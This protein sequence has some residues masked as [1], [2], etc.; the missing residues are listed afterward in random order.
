M[1]AKAVRGGRVRRGAALGAIGCAALCA[2]SALGPGSRARATTI[3]LMNLKELVQRAQKIVRGTVTNVQTELDHNHR[4]WTLYT[5]ERA[6]VAKGALAS[7]R[8]L[9]VRCIGGELEGHRQA[10]PGM[11]EFEL[12]AEV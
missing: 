4:L 7:S 9:R 8:L 5:L 12:G 1:P 3:R 11:P 10:V 6:A 2:L